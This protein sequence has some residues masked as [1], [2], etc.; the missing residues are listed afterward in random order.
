MTARAGFTTYMALLNMSFKIG[1][2]QST[3]KNPLVLNGSFFNVKNNSENYY[4]RGTTYWRGAFNFK[5][6][7]GINK[8]RSN[9]GSASNSNI[10][11]NAEI[12]TIIKLYDRIFGNI[13]LEGFVVN[14]Q[15]YETSSLNL[16]YRPKQKNY[17]FGIQAQNLWDT[18]TYTFSSVSDYQ[19]NDL[20]YTAIPRYAMLYFKLRF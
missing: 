6:T 11:Y 19:R 2:N 13:K 7:G 16:E 4:F 12:E 14:D 8:S 9:L 20:V 18:E 10:I 5:F 17:L 15:F 1:V 3:L